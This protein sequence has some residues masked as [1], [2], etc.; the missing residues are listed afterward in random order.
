MPLIRSKNGLQN[1]PKMILKMGCEMPIKYAG[2]R[3]SF[4]SKILLETL[5]GKKFFYASMLSYPAAHCPVNC[6][7]AFLKDSGQV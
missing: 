2:N 7:I 1:M 6:P 3:L 5:K 4:I